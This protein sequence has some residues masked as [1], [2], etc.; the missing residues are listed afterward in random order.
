MSAGAR[1]SL[2]AAVAGALVLVTQGPALALVP[3][4]SSA[5]PLVGS[6]VVANCPAGSGGDVAGGSPTIGD[7]SVGDPA[8]GRCAPH[9]AAADGVY[10][11]QGVSSDHGLRF[12]ADCT[13]SG[14]TFG[15]VD[16]PAGTTVNGV[17]VTQTTTITEPNTPVTFADGTDAVVNQVVETPDSVTR[18]A[19]VFEDGTIVGQAVCG[20][21]AAYPLAVGAGGGAGGP[22]GIPTAGT[23][24]E[25]SAATAVMLGAGLVVAALAAQVVA[26]RRLRA[27]RAG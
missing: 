3:E 22:A 15:A 7:V 16:V 25:S 1:A 18:N 12:T 17:V 11:I 24:S 5:T 9:A 10:E 20:Q 14:V 8:G 23:G 2:V 19:I 21:A 13:S 4:D 26:A 6:G 27:R